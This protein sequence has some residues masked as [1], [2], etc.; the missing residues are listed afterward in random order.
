MSAR[1]RE[2]MRRTGSRKG[3][4]ICHDGV[5]QVT[6]NVLHGVDVDPV[7]FSRANG[8]FRLLRTESLAKIITLGHTLLRGHLY[9]LQVLE[10]LYLS[11]E[12]M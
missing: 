11:R 9:R 5:L 6:C 7:P 12:D 8:G 10:R 2:G 3:I 1:Y 4:G